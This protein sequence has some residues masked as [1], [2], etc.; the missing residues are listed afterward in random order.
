[1]QF[2]TQK[3]QAE[4]ALYSWACGEISTEQAKR[5]CWDF[6]FDVD[7]RQPDNGAEMEAKRRA[8][9]RIVYLEV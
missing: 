6:G 8:D 2:Y 5:M 9:G 3:I 7:F 1:M 4:R